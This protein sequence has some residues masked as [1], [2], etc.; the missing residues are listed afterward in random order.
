MLPCLDGDND[1]DDDDNLT[2]LS[3]GLL[4]VPGPFEPSSLTWIGVD[5]D[6]DDAREGRDGEGSVLIA[7]FV[8]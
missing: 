5:E 4:V 1:N 6:D 3:G 7:A 8:T 2:E